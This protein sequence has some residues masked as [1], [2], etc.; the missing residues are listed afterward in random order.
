MKPT[1]IKKEIIDSLI[2]KMGIQDFAMPPFAR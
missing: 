2:A 1:P